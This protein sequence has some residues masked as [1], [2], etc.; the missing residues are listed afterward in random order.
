MFRRTSSAAARGLQ[1]CWLGLM[2]PVPFL[3]ADSALGV[4][5]W[6]FVLPA[7]LPLIVLPAMIWRDI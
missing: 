6:Y 4:G 1:Y 3:L 2:L 5:Q 7:T